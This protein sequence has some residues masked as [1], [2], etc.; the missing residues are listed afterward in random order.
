LSEDRFNP[1]K[2]ERDAFRVLLYVLA[3]AAVVLVATLII[4][5]L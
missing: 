4:Q 3:V 2:H 5:S 1:L